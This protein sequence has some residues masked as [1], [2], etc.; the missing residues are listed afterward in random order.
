MVDSPVKKPAFFLC[1]CFSLEGIFSSGT[2]S[3]ELTCHVSDR[4]PNEPKRN[5]LASN[6]WRGQLTR[7]GCL[8]EDDMDPV[9]KLSASKSM[10]GLT[11]LS[12][13]L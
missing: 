1:V 10:E 11:Y 8:V 12:L 5:L 9:G 3:M 13:L 7:D 4:L 6:K 2:G